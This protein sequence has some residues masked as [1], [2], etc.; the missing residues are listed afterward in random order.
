MNLA[1]INLRYAEG[2]FGQIFAC[3]STPGRGS[4][5]LLTV[6][7]TEGSLSL[8]SYQSPSLLLFRPGKPAGE[9][10]HTETL[11]ASWQSSFVFE[12][13]HFLDVLQLGTPLQARPEDGRAN[14]ELV[15]AAYKS[16]H[17]GREIPL[18]RR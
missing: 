4:V 2:Y 6:Y 18:S 16:A 12:I 7:G 1:V 8:N 3:H 11:P 14:L 5:P 15:L 17:T 9:E 10:L 13:A